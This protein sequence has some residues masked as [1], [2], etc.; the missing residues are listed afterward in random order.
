GG[1]N[2]DRQN[3]NGPAVVAYYVVVGPTQP[4]EERLGDKTEEAEI[5]ET[6]EIA[7]CR[8]ASAGVIIGMYGR[9]N[10]ERFRTHENTLPRG[11]A[12]IT[13][14]CSENR[15]RLVFVGIRLVQV[16]GNLDRVMQGNERRRVRVVRKKDRHEVL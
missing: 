5:D 6:L 14:G 9:K 11:P 13:D 7:V 16:L 12:W 3:K 15:D 8:G 4:E 10:V 2:D 1:V